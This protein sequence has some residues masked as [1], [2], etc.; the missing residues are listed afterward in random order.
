[1]GVCKGESW[2]YIIKASNIYHNVVSNTW[3]KGSL[4]KVLFKNMRWYTREQWRSQLDN[5]GGGGGT[6][7]YIRVLHYCLLKL[8]VFKVCWLRIYEY[9][10]PPPTY[11]A[12]YATAKEWAGKGEGRNF[13]HNLS[14]IQ[15]KHIFLLKYS[16]LFCAVSVEY[17]DQ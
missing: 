17:S 11:R 5:G 14:V 12:G 6:Y 7:S 15:Q 3:I 4:A 1:M 2:R 10:P 16:E 9:A 8:I 13:W